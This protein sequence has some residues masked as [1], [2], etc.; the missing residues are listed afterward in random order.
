MMKSKTHSWPAGHWHWPIPIAHYHG[1]RRGG[2]IFTGGQADLNQRGEIVNPENLTQQTLNVIDHVESILS[3]LDGS[4]NDL[5]KLVIYFVGD[6]SSET[7][8]LNLIANRLDKNTRP[9][10]STICLPSLCYPGMRIELEAVAIDPEYRSDDNPVYKRGS[11]L[12]AL[13]AQYS[14]AVRCNDLIFTSDLSSI[15]YQGELQAA[16]DLAQQTQVMMENLGAALALFD[17]TPDDVLKLNVFYLGDGTADNW[18][19]PA[20][21]RA[22][23]FNTPGPAATGITVT[24]FAVPGLMTK[25]AATAAVYEHTK[26]RQEAVRYAWPE[27][28]W[29]WTTP[30]P[31][32]H[33]NNFRGV[34][35]L[36]GQVALDEQAQVRYPDDIVQQAKIALTNI[37]TL[38]AEFGASMDDVVKVTTFYQ[39]SASAEALHENLLIRSNAFSTPGPATSGIPVPHLVYESMVI[40]IEVIAIV[41]P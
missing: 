28:H 17:A 37:N 32:Q 5:V 6:A 1:V 31:Y 12:P 3:D 19:G 35:H 30:L 11:E 40:E 24:G 27:G 7:Q 25:I 41:E 20:A 33:A 22:A 4:L 18:E 10:V 39:G 8:I 26:T 9:V 34:I 14:H 15:D 36:G 38:L 2:F 21:I 23:F 29:N 16:G 13:P